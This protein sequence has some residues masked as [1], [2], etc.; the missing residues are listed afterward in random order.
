MLKAVTYQ[1]Y[2][3]PEF[4]ELIIKNLP[5]L[6]EYTHLNTTVIVNLLSTRVYDVSVS[7]EIVRQFGAFSQ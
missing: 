7:E 6:V 4:T 3:K 2:T 1:D 5:E